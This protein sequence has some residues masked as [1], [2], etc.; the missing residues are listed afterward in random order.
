[1]AKSHAAYVR[2]KAAQAAA[3]QPRPNALRSCTL[4]ECRLGTKGER[5][6]VRSRKMTKADRL[7]QL[8]RLHNFDDIARLIDV[9]V[10]VSDRIAAEKA[11][12]LLVDYTKTMHPD[13]W[14][15]MLAQDDA[16]SAQ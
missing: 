7:Y 12:Q 10:K 16:I 13:C 2:K 11:R 5:P 14:R 4:R 1:M 6:N 9:P 3:Y 15:Q 8:A